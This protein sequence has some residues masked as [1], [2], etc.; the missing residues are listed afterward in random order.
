MY[1][2]IF[3]YFHYFYTLVFQRKPMPLKTKTIRATMEGCV[4]GWVGHLV[5]GWVSG[6]G[7]VGEH[8]TVSITLECDRAGLCGHWR[9]GRAVFDF[10]DPTHHFT[11]IANRLYSKYR[12]EI[13]R[14]HR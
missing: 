5:G 9:L 4:G 1:S 2:S 3:V 11:A 10:L 7:G 8:R 13:Q 14:E 6:W 12:I